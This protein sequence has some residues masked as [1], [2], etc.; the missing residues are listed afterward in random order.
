MIEE[1]KKLPE[2][3]RMHCVSIVTPN[4]LHFAPA[5]LAME[6]GFHV[7]C[8]KRLTRTLEE[9]KE[10]EKLVEETGLIFALTDTYIGYAM[11]K[12]ERDM[13]KNGDISEVRKIR[14]E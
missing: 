6:N 3:V 12:Q 13:V 4:H 5:K 14:V 10:L 11:E 7:I 2:D 1:E 8:D 9:A